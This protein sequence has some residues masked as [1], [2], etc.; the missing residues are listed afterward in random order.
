MALTDNRKNTQNTKNIISNF[1]NSKRNNGTKKRN[2]NTDILQKNTN[3]KR[4]VILK[5]NYINMPIRR[6]N[7]S[8][9]L[10]I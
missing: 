5:E 7:A 8:L 2:K 9:Q 3:P 10:K 6:E 1:I 4:N